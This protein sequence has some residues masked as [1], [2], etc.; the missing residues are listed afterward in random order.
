MS[1]TLKLSISED[2]TMNTENQVLWYYNMGVYKMINIAFAGTE[3]G[4]LRRHT[5]NDRFQQTSFELA[6]SP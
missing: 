2:W 3:K 1:V 4:V 6:I 5:D